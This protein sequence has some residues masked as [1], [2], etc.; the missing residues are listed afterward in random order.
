MQSGPLPFAD[1]AFDIV[2][3]KDALVEAPDKELLFAEARRVL[4]PEGW[5][6][7][8]DW[9]RSDGPISPQLQHWVDFSGSQE[10]PHSFHLA[11]LS[12]TRHTLRAL[13]YVEIE[14]KNENTWY[15]QEARRELALK[16]KHWRQ[17]VLLRGER[18]AEQSVAWHRAMIE[19]LDSG[20]FC[21]SCFRARKP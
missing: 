5:L 7:A 20:D 13:G 1:A 14:I 11:S 4:H 10:T 16:E 17:F 3:S 12:E 9:L 2:F 6:M 19:V 15:S 8:S 21:P 18:D